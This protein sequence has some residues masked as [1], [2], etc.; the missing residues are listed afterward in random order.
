MPQILINPLWLGVIC[1][2]TETIDIS[3]TE[4]IPTQCE[5]I[6]TMLTKM[7]VFFLK[8]NRFWTFL[9]LENLYLSGNCA[10]VFIS[11]PLWSN[12]LSLFAMC[13]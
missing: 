11:Y 1:V 3:M 12:F 4:T 9:L 6:L 2:N 10:T 8:K 5:L 7:Y 13:Q